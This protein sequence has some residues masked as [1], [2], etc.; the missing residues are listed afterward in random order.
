MGKRKYTHSQDEGQEIYR[1]IMVGAT[2]L[3]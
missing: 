2:R 1:F 3:N